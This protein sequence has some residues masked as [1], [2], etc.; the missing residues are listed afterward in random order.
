M[1]GKKAPINPETAK[2]N[3]QRVEDLLENLKEDAQKAIAEKDVY[4]LGVYQ[5]ILK[6]VSPITTRAAAR[7]RREDQAAINKSRIALVKSITQGTDQTDQEK[8]EK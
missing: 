6:V 7:L 1:A 5:E 2:A 8:P 4:M 3:L